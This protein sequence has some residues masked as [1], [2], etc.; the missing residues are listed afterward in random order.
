MISL[1][2]GTD[3][4]KH[5]DDLSAFRVRMGATSFDPLSDDSDQQQCLGILFR[6]ADIGHSAKDWSLHE[7]WSRRV[8]QEFH[9]QG[10]EEKSAGLKV[11]PLCD[12]DNFQLSSS[13][14][15]FL[16]FICL[17][18][19]TELAN[20]EVRVKEASTALSQSRVGRKSTVSSMGSQS[21]AS[22]TPSRTVTPRL[23]R[24]NS[25]GHTLT[26][27]A[28]AARTTQFLLLPG[29]LGTSPSAK[30]APADGLVQDSP[31]P[32]ARWIRDVCLAHCESNCQQWKTLGASKT[33]QTVVSDTSSHAERTTHGEAEQCPG[34]SETGSGH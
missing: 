30:V 3:T 6:A 9:T 15:G 26:V 25:L 20:L 12:R 10:D 16:T 13:Q 2:L 24:R 14:V 18:T 31:P 22:R 27:L 19:W 11:S 23:E 4:Q 28:G 32:P 21:P 5:L 7:E 29:A 34:G 17:P 8:V 33:V 1:I